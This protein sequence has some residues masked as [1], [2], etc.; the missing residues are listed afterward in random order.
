MEIQ[1]IVD[2]FIKDVLKLDGNDIYSKILYNLISILF[3]IISILVLILIV[4]VVLKIT[5]DKQK[6][7]SDKQK[8]TLFTVLYKTAKIVLGFLGVIQIINL[9]YD[10]TPILVALTSIGG[11]AIGFGAQSIVKDIVT[12]L[13]FLVENQ[14]NI[15]DLVEVGGQ[16]GKVEDIGL[17]TVKIRNID[18][19]LHIFPNGTIL[20]V[21]NAMK[22]Y[23]RCVIEVKVAYRED[24]M[25]VIDT[26]HRELQTL[27]T[28][29]TRIVH[30]VDKPTLNRLED[31]DIV[32]RILLD[33]AVDT[34]F[35]VALAVRKQLLEILNQGETQ[36]TITLKT[37]A[38]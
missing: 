32:I 12:G 6:K 38:N 18:G 21:T 16:I 10:N 28:N 35:A 34:Q 36:P 23:T 11:I 8:H 22:E 5:I 29:D 24:I 20:S 27:Q 13:F 30:T 26:I 31:E 3:I 2:T 9:F 4:R 1:T 14:F 19:R 33:T 15:G 17:R 37:T 25:G 7:W